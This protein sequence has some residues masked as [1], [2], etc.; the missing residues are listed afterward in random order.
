MGSE[1]S[2]TPT[3][4]PDYETLRR[5]IIAERGGMPK[6]LAQV[7][8]FAVDHPDEIAL[9]TVGS[10]AGQAGVQPSTLVRFAQALGFQGFSEFQ[11]VYR[12][13]LQQ[14]WPDY[15]DRINAL[16]AKANG[17]PGTAL[18]AGFSE[19]T[20]HSILK[21]RETCESEHLTAAARVIS[22][23]D[24]IYLIGNRRAFP[25][26]TYLGYLL[27][28]LDMRHRILTNMGEMG[29]S[30]LSGAS[31]RDA[32]IAISF[33]PYSPATV[34]IAT[35]AAERAVPVI[36][37]T[38]STFSPLAHMARV[39]LE[40]VEDDYAGFRSLGATFCLCMAL[41]TYAAKLRLEAS[42]QTDNSI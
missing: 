31:E 15:T 16:R 28:K 5:R 26:A 10:I 22:K 3:P 39:W 38:D 37:I 8:K 17:D 12:R 42:P 29:R 14:R 6:R 30:E 1:G 27:G 24:T 41:A 23:A 11:V 4:S 25:A 32:M 18:L 35:R 9:G 40:V 33:T 21:V 34:E 2:Q 7:A 13:Q 20:I 19:A 36:S